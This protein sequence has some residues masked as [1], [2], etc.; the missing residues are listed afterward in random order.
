M[1]TCFR[2][3]FWA[4][5]ARFCIHIGLS[6][7]QSLPLKRLTSF[8]CSAICSRRSST[9]CSIS[10]KL[11][12]LFG[13]FAAVASFV[14][15]MYMTMARSHNGARGNDKNLM[16]R[17][18]VGLSGDKSA[19][20]KTMLTLMGIQAATAWIL[21]INVKDFRT[22][23]EARSKF[24]RPVLSPKIFRTPNMLPHIVSPVESTPSAGAST[25]SRLC[26][27]AN[28]TALAGWKLSQED[29]TNGRDRDG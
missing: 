20:V 16:N 7:G 9:S 3:S 17:I 27:H 10:S 2:C 29:P 23:H 24:S 6:A 14:K 1:L 26:E 28:A 8:S 22:I 11:T 21:P 4:Y 12:S 18:V 15:W 19:M 13:T 5:D 25:L